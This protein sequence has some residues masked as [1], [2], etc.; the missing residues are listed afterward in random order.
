MADAKLVIKVEEDSESVSASSSTSRPAPPPETFAI[1][2]HEINPAAW[3]AFDSLAEDLKIARESAKPAGD[4]FKAMADTLMK[5][6]ES[7]AKQAYDAAGTDQAARF[8]EPPSPLTNP[9][10]RQ[11][12]G[13]AFEALDPMI[14]K[15]GFAYSTLD[16]SVGEAAYAAEPA[17]DAFKSLAESLVTAREEAA[18]AAYD[19]AGV[20]PSARMG[21]ATSSSTDPLMAR[22]AVGAYKA[23]EPTWLEKLAGSALKLPP[24][25]AGGAFDSLADALRKGKEEAAK[26]AYDAA[27]VSPSARFGSAPASSIDPVAAGMAGSPAAEPLGYPEPSPEKDAKRRAKGLAWRRQKT[28]ARRAGRLD[29]RRRGGAAGSALRRG[30]TGFNYAGGA[31]RGAGRVASGLARNSGVGLAGEAAN[32]IGT[33]ARGLS[34]LGSLGMAAGVG[35]G[36]VAASV[37]VFAGA[38]AAVS[39][40]TNAFVERGK[41]LQG[42]SAELSLANSMSEINRTLMDIREANELGPQLAELT[43]AQNRAELFFQDIWIQLKGPLIDFCTGSIE[44]IPQMLKIWFSIA[45]VA[46]LW[47]MHGD[48][49]DIKENIDRMWKKAS[50]PVAGV[51]DPIG[52]WLNAGRLMGAPAA[53]DARGIGLPVR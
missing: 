17:G 13:S 30:T 38:V 4:A 6:R 35:L 28:Y 11:L 42:Y 53:P 51:I 40:V 22:M 7:A 16:K 5:A 21:A 8:G 14:E 33:A 43:T 3:S 9:L 19:A 37:G 48:V 27:G 47:T 10:M 24:T 46:T 25:A 1:P 29:Y 34:S 31:V 39:E 32:A 23:P 45:D 50:E 44:A 52:L 26:A 36:A 49:K 15:L 41:Q 12:G 18:K 20:S 2:G